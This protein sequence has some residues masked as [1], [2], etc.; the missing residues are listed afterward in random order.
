[1]RISLSSDHACVVLISLPDEPRHSNHSVQRAWPHG[2]QAPCSIGPAAPDTNAK[3]LIPAARAGCLPLCSRIYDTTEVQTRRLNSATLGVA[4][5]SP[6]ISDAFRVGT[7]DEWAASKGRAQAP[8][9]FDLTKAIIS[10]SCS[11]RL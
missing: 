7:E 9:G 8:T 2:H 3:H 11:G 6:R 5:D 10:H 1:M 4:P